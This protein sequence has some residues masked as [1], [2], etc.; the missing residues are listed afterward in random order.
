MR[1]FVIAF[2]LLCCVA[3]AY[4]DGGRLRM[5]APAGP[6]TVTL[7]TTP[8][9]LR[10]DEADFSVALERA[11]TGELVDDARITLVLTPVAEGGRGRIE[12]PATH[13]AATSAFMQ[14]ADVKLPHGGDWTVT[15]VVREG[16]ESGECSTALE[17]LPA[18]P[19]G[20]QIFWEIMLVP[21]AL[22]FFAVHQRLKIRQRRRFQSGV[23]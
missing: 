15:V 22:L 6:F 17:V 16:R 12:L 5:H 23:S 18:S 19:L 11:A 1:R 14:A 10:A 21:F 2:G 9:P 13:Q 20:G 8:D 7:F 3:S 4:A